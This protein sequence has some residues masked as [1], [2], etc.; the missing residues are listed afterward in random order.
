M[1][2]IDLPLALRDE[3]YQ[4]EIA[5]ELEGYS[6]HT[7]RH[8]AAEEIENLRNALSRMCHHWDAL[9]NNMDSGEEYEARQK[10]EKL[11]NKEDG[12]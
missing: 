11:L 4:S 5:R 7:L 6:D 12:K 8:D 9:L 2:N 1:L 3:V 10:A